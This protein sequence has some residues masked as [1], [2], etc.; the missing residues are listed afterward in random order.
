MIKNIIAS[1]R[2]GELT[3]EQM[4]ELKTLSLKQVLDRPYLLPKLMK[5]YN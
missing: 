5:Y 2:W 1:I 4:D 3:K